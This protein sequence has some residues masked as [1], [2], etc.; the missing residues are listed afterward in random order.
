MCSFHL[1]KK[2]LIA[3]WH[4]FMMCLLHKLTLKKPCTPLVQ[5]WEIHAKCVKLCTYLNQV[6]W[7]MHKCE[8]QRATKCECLCDNTEEL[9]LMWVL[10]GFCDWTCKTLTELIW[11]RRHC[12]FPLSV[13]VFVHGGVCVTCMHTAC[14][15]LCVQYI[16][17]ANVN[18]GS[19]H[20]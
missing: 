1:L 20:R 12:R 13:C 18:S 3:T 2:S 7:I 8:K 16:Y 9:L 5:P 11:E 14:V 4:S 15:W 10:Y 17:C 6:Y 19:N